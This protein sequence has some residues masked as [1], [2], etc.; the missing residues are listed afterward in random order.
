MSSEQSM[1]EPA[2]LVLGVA[3]A[4]PLTVY[5]VARLVIGLRDEVVA[6]NEFTVEPSGFD[7]FTWRHHPKG[8]PIKRPVLAHKQSHR[9][10]QHPGP[11]R[12]TVRDQYGFRPAPCP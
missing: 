6:R 7:T 5:P 1:E 3:A 10:G 2:R 9:R 11:S 8:R 12:Q 4:H